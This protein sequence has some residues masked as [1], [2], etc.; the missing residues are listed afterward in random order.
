[1]S[2]S[3]PGWRSS[4]RSC[5]SPSCPRRGPPGPSEEAPAVN[6]TWSFGLTLACFTL[7]YVGLA[8]G[9]I[10]GLRIDRTGIALVGAALMLAS[11]VLTLD[12]A[13]RAVDFA[14]LLLLLGM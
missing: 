10:P 13:V 12:D 14:T 6:G 4:R 1:P 5:S 7:T 3:S 2:T 11:R 9:R 8:L